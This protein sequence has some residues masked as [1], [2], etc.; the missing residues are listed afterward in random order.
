MVFCGSFGMIV[1]KVVRDP[2]GS[3]MS[4]TPAIKHSLGGGLGFFRGERG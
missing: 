2:G 4:R 1:S 3:L